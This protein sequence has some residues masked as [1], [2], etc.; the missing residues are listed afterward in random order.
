MEPEDFA[1]FHIITRHYSQDPSPCFQFTLETKIRNL[2]GIWFG[3][4]CF[5]KHHQENI[6][7]KEKSEIY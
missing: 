4:S 5:F 3:E 7:M 6:S 1:K 2:Q